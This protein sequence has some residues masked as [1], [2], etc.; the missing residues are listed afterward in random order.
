MIDFDI[1]YRISFEAHI[2]TLNF[3]FED[4]KILKNQTLKESKDTNN[5]RKNY[6]FQEYLVFNQLYNQM[7]K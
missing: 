5:N 1:M 7:Y 3:S 6:A 4:I 2:K